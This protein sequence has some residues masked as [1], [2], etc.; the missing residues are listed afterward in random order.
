MKPEPEMGPADVNVSEDHVWLL[1]LHK[2]ILS[3]E[4]VEENASKS[5]LMVRKGTLHVNVL[6]TPLQMITVLTLSN[7]VCYCAL[8]WCWHLFC[9]GPGKLKRKTAKPCIYCTWIALLMYKLVRVTVK[10]WLLITSDT[11]FN[12]IIMFI[13]WCRCYSSVANVMPLKSYNHTL[14]GTW[15]K[16]RDVMMPS[17]HYVMFLLKQYGHIKRQKPIKPVIW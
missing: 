3:L 11:V 12:A 16:V 14:H 2:N 1:L 7:Y 15:L 4:I 8:Y 5:L 9:D 17:V 6:R 13:L 10:I